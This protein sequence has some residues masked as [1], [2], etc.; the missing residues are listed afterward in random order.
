[1]V[2]IERQ[3]D[4]PDFAGGFLHQLPGRYSNLSLRG[5]RNYFKQYTRRSSKLLLTRR[6]PFSQKV[7]LDSQG[8]MQK[9]I[10]SVGP[11]LDLIELTGY[12]IIASELRQDQ[13]MWDIARR[14][15]DE[16]FRKNPPGMTFV[17]GVLQ[18]A[19]IPTLFAPGELIRTGWRAQVQQ[20]LNNVPVEENMRGLSLFGLHVSRRVKHP[21][22]LIR[23]LGPRFIGGLYRGIDVF[24]ATYFADIPEVSET[25]K[26]LRA[27][28]LIESLWRNKGANGEDAGEETAYQ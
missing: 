21:S 20:M 13:E 26:R 22:A 12:A 9:G 7:Q 16:Y 14:N 28:D 1:M 8:L 24:A 5:T 27:N 15:W 10:V 17:A 4:I 25:V 6:D 23:A 2:S 3:A 19:D 18:L 11:V